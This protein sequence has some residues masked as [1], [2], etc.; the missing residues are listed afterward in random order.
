MQV[1]VGLC[2]PVDVL[3]AVT[4]RGSSQLSRGTVLMAVRQDAH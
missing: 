3:L 4:G 1:D 2:E